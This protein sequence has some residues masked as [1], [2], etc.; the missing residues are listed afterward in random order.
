MTT[1][2]ILACKAHNQ[3]HMKKDKHWGSF[4]PIQGIEDN[5]Y[6]CI[7]LSSLP[8]RRLMGNE[9]IR[10]MEA[11]EDITVGGALGGE[12]PP[13][14]G[15]TLVGRAFRGVDPLLVGGSVAVGGHWDG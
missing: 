15:A 10:L 4:A 7:S 13:L 6:S 3:P 2:C 5:S 14:G 8:I 11:E 1:Y 12:E 9:I